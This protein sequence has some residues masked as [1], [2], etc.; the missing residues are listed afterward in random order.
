MLYTMTLSS[1]GGSI[2]NV[3]VRISSVSLTGGQTS[4]KMTLEVWSVGNTNAISA[5]NPFVKRASF[6]WILVNTGTPKTYWFLPGV[7]QAGSSQFAVGLGVSHKGINGY[8]TGDSGLTM[9]NDTADAFIS[10]KPPDSITAY[11]AATTPVFF[12]AQATI[13]CVVTINGVTTVS[14]IS[15]VTS[16]PP[17]FLSSNPGNWILLVMLLF[18]PAGIMGAAMRGATG[19]LV[20]LTIGAIAASAAG[21]LP[22][23]GLFLIGL[24]DLLL[25]FAMRK[26]E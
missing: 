8:L 5:Q 17:E 23:Y 9:N 21:I 25:I 12:G 6:T 1:G 19:L 2:L 7:G 24:V 26:G 14:A 13:N 3:S 10:Q 4:A 16:L 22:L 11:T 15:T 18:L 20:G